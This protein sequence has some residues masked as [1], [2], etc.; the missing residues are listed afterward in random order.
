MTRYPIRSIS[1]EEGLSLACSFVA[2]EAR[3]LEFHS[4]EE[5]V[6]LIL[7]NQKVERLVPEV[8]LADV[9]PYFL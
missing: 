7:G 2:G 6:A 5:L 3:R 9:S 1:R 8:G 4:W